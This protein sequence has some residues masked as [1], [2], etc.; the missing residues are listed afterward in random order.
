MQ[1]ENDLSSTAPYIVK[2]INTIGKAG[3]NEVYDEDINNINYNNKNYRIK[4]E[5][6]PGEGSKYRYYNYKLTI[7]CSDNRKLIIEVIP[8]E[9]EDMNMHYYN[10]ELL[11]TYKMLSG[12]DFKIKSV[13]YGWDHNNLIDFSEDDYFRRSV[14]GEDN[15][16]LNITSKL[17][18]Y[19]DS[20]YNSKELIVLSEVFDRRVE[21][22]IEKNKENIKEAEELVDSLSEEKIRYLR[23]VLEKHNK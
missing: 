5:T 18:N 22:R 15:S 11:I 20:F 12:I 17:M 14:Y 7:T 13:F 3:E 10:T 8:Q 19:L 1:K 9:T 2:L 23:K 4:L 21:N 6:N 16:V